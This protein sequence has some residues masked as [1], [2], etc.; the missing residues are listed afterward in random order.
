MP[1]LRLSLPVAALLAFA[2]L[3]HAD[4]SDLARM[5]KDLFFLASEECEGRGLKTEGIHKAAAYIAESFKAAGLKPAGKDGS[6]FQ[7]FGIKET[8]LEAGPHK[9]TLTGPDGKPVDPAFN[10]GFT[11]SGLSGRGTIGGGLVFAGYGI[12]SDKYD[13]YQGL[14]VK[15]RV[16]VVLRQVP[17]M[18][19]KKDALYSQDEVGKHAP[20]S[21]K[22]K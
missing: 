16:V 22:I 18:G 20:L 1:R 13:D 11:V 7:P 21:A 12:T 2:P 14:D 4:D 5:K 6:Y 10:K 17:R 3:L 8:Y 9:L 15:N 19:A